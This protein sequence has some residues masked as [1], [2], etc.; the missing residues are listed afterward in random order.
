ME[1]VKIPGEAPG[2]ATYYMVGSPE[3]YGTR[4]YDMEHFGDAVIREALIDIGTERTQPDQEISSFKEYDDLVRKSKGRKVYS[5]RFAVTYKSLDVTV[6][7][8]FEAK[9]LTLE[10][11]PT[12]DGKQKKQLAEFVKILTT[13]DYYEELEMDELEEKQQIPKLYRYLAMGAGVVLI[14]AIGLDLTKAFPEFAELTK[15]MKWMSMLFLALYFVWLDIKR[16]QQKRK[17]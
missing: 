14:V 5:C 15:W 13:Q 7:P 3:E 8:D 1:R 6:I 11:D 9:R 17:R 12:I 4:L 2:S 10:V 16:R